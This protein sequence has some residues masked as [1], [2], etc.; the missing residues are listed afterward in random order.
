MIPAVL[1]PANEADHQMIL[2]ALCGLN[3]GARVA[4]GG[5]AAE[6]EIDMIGLVAEVVVQHQQSPPQRSKP[7][8]QPHPR[9]HLQLGPFRTGCRTSSQAVL[10]PANLRHQH[11][12][13]QLSTRSPLRSHCSCAASFSTIT[14]VR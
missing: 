13:L 3:G 7:R 1:P 12:G 9:L 2:A 8:L 5:R 11:L 4:V 14:G 6:A 10:R